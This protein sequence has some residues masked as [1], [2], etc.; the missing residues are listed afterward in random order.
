MEMRKYLIMLLLVSVVAFWACDDDEEG[1][2][3][4]YIETQCENPWGA[5]T[6]QENYIVEVTAYLE[7]DGIKVLMIYIDEYDD[8]VGINCNVYSGLTGRNIIVSVPPYDVDEAKE[9]GF[10]LME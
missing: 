10:T 9:L 7:N 8:T 2:S 3:M 6:T 1:M 5:A 4:Q